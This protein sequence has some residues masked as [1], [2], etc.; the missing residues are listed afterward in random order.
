LAGQRF[1]EVNLKAAPKDNGLVLQLDGKTLAGHVYLPLKATSNTPIGV[2]L[3]RLWLGRDGAS[4]M[5]AKKDVDPHQIPP[6]WMSVKDL[7]W[8]GRSLGKLRFALMPEVR[9]LRLTHLQLN[10]AEH[11]IT[12]SGHWW[13]KTPK[14]VSHLQA[15]LTSQNLGKTL[16]AFGYQ[17]A[18]K[19]GQ[20]KAQLAVQW[21]AP[22][23]AIAPELIDGDLE[24]TITQGRLLDVEPGLG[25]L[26]GLLNIS[27]LSRRL[28]LD[29]SDLF[30]EGFGFDQLDGTV[31]FENGHA[32]NNVAIKAP[33]AQVH[34]AGRIGFQERDYRQTVTVTPQVGSPLAI[35]GAIAGG[36]AV[37]AAVLLAERI[38]KPGIDQITRY[39]YFITG[40]WD[41]PVVQPRKVP[42]VVDPYSMHGGN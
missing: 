33:A 5:T 32:Y 10:G 18:L 40:S 25:R 13:H 26:V 1:A 38:F 3:Q 36:P 42:V 37:G 28:Q 12:A 19:E 2:Q 9:G 7:A 17:D 20:A 27:S 8:D 16:R 6:L 23:P 22:F 31:R 14:P 39:Q 21:Q 34:L 24:L 15:T 11:R 29:F 35:A 30:K 4:D 41:D